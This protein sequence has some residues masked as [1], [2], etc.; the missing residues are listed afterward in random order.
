MIKQFENV[1]V[2]IIDEFSFL[3]P[4]LLY[5]LNKRLKELK[6]GSKEYFGNCCVLLFGDIMQLKPVQGNYIFEEPTFDKF[7]FHDP[8]ESLWNKQ[9]DV[10]ELY[11]NHRQEEDKKYAD[12][13]S[14]LRFKNQDYDNQIF[15]DDVQFLK[16]RMDLNIPQDALFIAGTNKIVNKINET[17]LNELT[18]EMHVHHAI[19][20][21]PTGVQPRITETGQ[22]KNTPF[23]QTLTLKVG[24]R[25]MLTFNIDTEDGLTNGTMGT[26][27]SFSK[28]KFNHLHTINIIFDNKSDGKKIRISP[29]HQHSQDVTPISKL[30][31]M[32]AIGRNQDPTSF[33]GKAIQ[34]PLKLAYAATVHKCQGITIKQPTALVADLQSIFEPCQAYVLLSRIQTVNQLFISKFE[35]KRKPAEKILKCSQK[36]L[37]EALRMRE[38]AISLQDIKTKREIEWKCSNTLNICLLNIR[39]LSKS[40]IEEGIVKDKYIMANDVLIFP[41]TWEHSTNNLAIPTYSVTNI[42]GICGSGICIYYKQ[43]SF[44]PIKKYDNNVQV[45]TLSNNNLNIIGLYKTQSAKTSHLQEALKDNIQIE[46]RNPTIILGKKV[47]YVHFI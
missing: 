1:H 23:L 17:K 24:A 9:F 39:S 45:L 3:T 32:F 20:M 44:T 8:N 35:S 46:K 6:L 12:L 31:F 43:G 22:I 11:E 47:N 15:R 40:K 41:E 38:K 28:D 18:T 42:P 5:C 25:I 37:E 26:V 36:A 7:L 29:N 13:L 34:F 14:R 27:D 19:I 4:N 16:Q 2:I 21:L 33:K 10:Y 30:E